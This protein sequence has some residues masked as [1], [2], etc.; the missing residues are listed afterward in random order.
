MEA[1][2]EYKQPDKMTGLLR[3]LIDKDPYNKYCVDC[4]IRESTHCSVSYGVFLCGPCAQCHKQELG[5]QTSYVKDVFHEL[6]D[7]FQLKMVVFG[8]NK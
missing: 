2:E 7:E 3:D 5:M 4:N 8:G 6:W 1:A